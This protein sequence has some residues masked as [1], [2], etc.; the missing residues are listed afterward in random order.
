M[1]ACVRACVRV[2]VHARACVSE[3]A[4][5]VRVCACITNTSAEGQ[6]SVKLCVEK[7]LSKKLNSPGEQVACMFSSTIGV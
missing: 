3:R 2:C 6:M 7:S 5:L 1:C 4:V